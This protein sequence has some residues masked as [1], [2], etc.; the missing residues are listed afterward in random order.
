MA[1][2]ILVACE[3]SQVVTKAFRRLG[4]IAFSCD[5]AECS[6]GHPEWHIQDDARSLDFS[7]YDLV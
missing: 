4:H 1:A 3:R 2:Q 5:I 6:G 7:N